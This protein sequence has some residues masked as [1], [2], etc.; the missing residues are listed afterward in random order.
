MSNQSTAQTAE[1][2]AGRAVL[3]ISPFVANDDDVLKGDP[4]ESDPLLL[5]TGILLSIGHVTDAS[6][7]GAQVT[8]ADSL[9]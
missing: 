8:Y 5:V 9:S 2:S 4:Y 6:A 1:F 3:T 7:R